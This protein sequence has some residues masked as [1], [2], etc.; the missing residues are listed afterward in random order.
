MICTEGFLEGTRT[1][2]EAAVSFVFV[3]GADILLAVLWCHKML[4]TPVSLNLYS[5]KSSLTYLEAPRKND[6]ISVPWALWFWSG[7]HNM[8]VPASLLASLI[9]LYICS[10]KEWFI[11][12]RNQPMHR[13]EYI[14]FS[15]LDPVYSPRCR[16]YPLHI[17]YN[18]PGDRR[19]LWSY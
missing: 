15:K 3:A 17:P 16:S 14:S 4:G 11:G 6:R 5:V 19:I 8:T 9:G 18:F 10:S 7:S 13:I 2:M 12:L 1:S